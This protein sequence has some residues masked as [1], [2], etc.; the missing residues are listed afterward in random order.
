MSSLMDIVEL[1][2]TVTIR[3]TPIK[4][5]GV[6]IVFIGEIFARFPKIRELFERK[7]FDVK[8]L[9][10][11]GGPVLAA[12]IAAGTGTPGDKDAEAKAAMLSA[13]E[14]A[15]LVESIWRL[16]FPKGLGALL[17][18]LNALG[19]QVVAPSGKAPDTGSR[20]PQRN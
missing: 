8:L 10:D 2:D 12:I 18:A 5:I 16:T 9:L 17:A 7:N 20:K 15:E 4:T 1:S 3:G 6:S 14:Q 11:V 13:G 19:V